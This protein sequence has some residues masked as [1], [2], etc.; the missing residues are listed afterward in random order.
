MYAPPNMPAYPNPAGPFADFA[1]SVTPFVCWIEDYPLLDGLKMPSHIGSYDGK[2]DP[3][4]FLHLFEGFVHGLR[5]RSLVEHLSTDLPSNYKGLM[6]KTYTWVEA[7]ENSDSGG[8]KLGLTLAP[9]KR[10]KKERTKS[11]DT[12]RRESRKDK[13]KAPAKT[14]ILMDSQENVPGPLVK[15]RRT[16]MQRIGIV[17]STIHE[18]IKFHTK[19]GIRTVLSTD[20]ASEEDQKDTCH[21]LYTDGTSNSDGS[22]A[23]LILIDLEGKEYTY[24]LCFEFATT[25]NKPEYEALL[26]DA[27]RKMASMTFEHLTKE[28]LVEVLTKRS[29]EEKKLEVETQERK[30]W[31]DLIHEYLLSGLLLENTRETRKIRIQAPQYKLIRGNLYKRSFFMPWHCCV[32]PPQTDKIIKEIHEG[33][34][35]F[36][37]EPRSLVVRLTKQGFY[38]PSM[39]MEVTKAIQDCEKCKEE[40]AVRKA[41]TSEAIAGNHIIG[42]LPMAP[43]D[44]EYPGQSAQKKRNILKKGY[45]QTFVKD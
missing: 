10:N 2:G 12:P 41:R 35:I 3:D 24:A 32:A 4:N 18:A 21:K 44:S 17:V 27:L 7:R 23:W 8:C 1:G 22:K 45:S 30:S 42:P 20:E 13:G 31:M 28:V 39:H 40:S 43:R 26:A 16:T 9:C 25:N 14:P 34:C 37:A 38:W 36:N 11:S 19:K 15:F 29:I 6:E 33:S 5:T